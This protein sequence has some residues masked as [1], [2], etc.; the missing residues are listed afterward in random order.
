MTE[1]NKKSPPEGGNF[2]LTYYG[3]GKMGLEFTAEEGE[4]TGLSVMGGEG[5]TG[6]EGLGLTGRL[7]LTGSEGEGGRVGESETIGESLGDSDGD[8]D[9]DSEGDSVGSGEGDSLRSPKISVGPL[10]VGVLKVLYS[11]PSWIGCIILRH[12]WAAGL[13]ETFIRSGVS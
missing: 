8:S 2:L 3:V 12:I 6:K 5:S 11:R 7:G 9:G 13:P 10:K 4:T 1:Y